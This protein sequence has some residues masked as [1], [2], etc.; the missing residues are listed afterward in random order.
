[1]A[2]PLSQI[3]KSCTFTPSGGS[4][5]AITGVQDVSIA[6]RGSVHKWSGDGA[7]TVQAQSLEDIEAQ[8]T[9]T[10]TD[11]SWAKNTGLK[12]GTAGALVVVWAGRGP[13][14]GASGADVTATATYCLVESRE[15]TAPHRG[16]S[17]LAITFSAVHPDGG[18]VIAYT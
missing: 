5:V 18:D 17:A 10:T 2:A 14:G 12:P 15:P 4:A 8:I 1:M 13:R 16:A 3:I 11:V 9:V 7:A 6:E